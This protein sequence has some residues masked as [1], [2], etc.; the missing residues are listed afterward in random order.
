MARDGGHGHRRMDGC[1]SEKVQAQ[2][3]VLAVPLEQRDVDRLGRARSCLRAYL[4]T[5]LP[6]V[7]EHP[8]RHEEP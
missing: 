8:W 7:S 6:R 1:L 4:P 5:A 2:L 3:G